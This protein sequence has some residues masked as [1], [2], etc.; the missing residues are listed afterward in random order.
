M[1]LHAF[2]ACNTEATLNLFFSNIPSICTDF[3][4][5][6]DTFFLKDSTDILALCETYLNTY[7]A[8]DESSMLSSILSKKKIKYI[9]TGSLSISMKIFHLQWDPSL[10]SPDDYSLIFNFR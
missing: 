5:E 2:P 3:S 6:L 8:T 1:S 4:I 9:S 7:I 10:K